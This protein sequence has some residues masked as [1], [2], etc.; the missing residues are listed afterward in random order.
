MLQ[1]TTAKYHRLPQIDI[2]LGVTSF[3]ICKFFYLQWGDR[4]LHFRQAYKGLTRPLLFLISEPNA[5]FK[6]IPYQQFLCFFCKYVM[7]VL[8]L[9][10]FSVRNFRPLLSF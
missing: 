6:L 8:I 7:Q 10:D 3:P 9:F 4:K 5:S 1:R 2:L